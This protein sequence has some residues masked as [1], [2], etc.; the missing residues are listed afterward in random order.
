MNLIVLYPQPTDVEK[1]KADYTAHVKLLHQ[2][3]GIPI[4]VKPYTITK[5]LPSLE[6]NTPYYQMFTMPFDSLEALNETMSSS[7][8]Q[9]VAADAN[10][11]STGGAPTILIGELT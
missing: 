4:D 8:M 2:K 10:R 6:G 7:G 3:T 1:F 5:F 9:E 11:I